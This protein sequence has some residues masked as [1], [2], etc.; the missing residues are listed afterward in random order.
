MNRSKTKNVFAVLLGLCHASKASGGFWPS[1][2]PMPRSGRAAE[3][4]KRQVGKEKRAKQAFISLDFVTSSFL[5]LV[6]RPGAPSSVL[7]PSSD[8][9]SP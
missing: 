1:L 2:R 6:V 9:R 7:A 5:L 3:G 4:T 8:A